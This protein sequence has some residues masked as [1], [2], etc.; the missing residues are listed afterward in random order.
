MSAVAAVRWWDD[1][2]QMAVA[3]AVPTHV[4]A[5]GT[6]AHAAIELAVAYPETVLSLIL[7]DPTFDVEQH[8]YLLASVAV[9][10]LV[11]ASA[12]EPTTDL[13]ISQRLAGDIENAVFVVID[14]AANPVHTG[15]RESFREWTSSFVTIAEGLA[16]RSGTALTPPTP[17]VEGAFR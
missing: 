13:T 12:P 4:F 5:A 1:D 3:A 9:P 2:A 15:N 7:A 14:D 11:I 8:A 6:D 16:L 10:T 17:L